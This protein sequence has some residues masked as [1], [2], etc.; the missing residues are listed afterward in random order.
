MG[1][2]FWGPDKALVNAQAELLLQELETGEPV[3]PCEYRGLEASDDAVSSEP[4]LT[5]CARLK[6]RSATV[7]QGMSLEM[8]MWWRDHEAS[9]GHEQAA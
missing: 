1:C 3:D 8:Q 6:R 4:G 9:E 5:L 2:M 7:I